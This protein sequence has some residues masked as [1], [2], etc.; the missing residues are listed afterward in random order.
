MTTNISALP[1]LKVL[2]GVQSDEDFTI[3]LALTQSDGVTP[4]DL[5]GISFSSKIGS[6][7]TIT[8]ANGLTV[9]GNIISWTVLAAQKSGWPTG[10][11]DFALTASDGTDTRDVFAAHSKIR[12]GEDLS[13]VVISVSSATA[14]SGSAVAVPLPAPL[15]AAVG[16]AQASAA[17]AFLDT[18]I[19]G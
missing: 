19:F 4:L 7:A 9:S 6:F 18:L 5:S 16:A 17:Q 1:L 13:L 3:S 14:A 8:T 15:A 2:A 12:I 10:Q 11:Y